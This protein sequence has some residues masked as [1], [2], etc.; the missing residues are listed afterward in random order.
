VQAAKK[1]GKTAEE[2]AKTWAT[3]AKYK[4]YPPGAAESIAYA[5]V[6]FNETK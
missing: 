4:G 6:I 1:A 2:A 3:P 5:Q